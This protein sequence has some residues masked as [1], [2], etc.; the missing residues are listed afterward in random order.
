MLP[1]LACSRVAAGCRARVCRDGAV[2]LLGS[3]VYMYCGLSCLRLS[4]GAVARW[5]DSPAMAILEQAPV[6]VIKRLLQLFPIHNLRQ[7]WPKVGSKDDICAEIAEERRYDQIIQFLDESL[8]CCKQHVYIYARPDGLRAPTEVPDGERIVR[9]GAYSLFL[10]KVRYSVILRETLVRQHVD[11]LWPV[12]IELAPRHLIVRLVTLEKNLASYVNGPYVLSGRSID[13][14][15]VLESFGVLEATDLH[16]GIKALWEEGFMDSSRAKYKKPRSTAW[17]AMDEQRG[18][19]E[20]DPG[21]YKEL[22]KSTLHEALFQIPAESG[23]SVS[24]FQASPASGYLAFTRYSKTKGDTDSVV[25]EIL[26]R[27]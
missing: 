10:V 18:I 20:H 2:V 26:G 8:S 12:R 25:R 7:G 24:A 27:N 9:A 6:Q 1:F 14:D 17:E 21:L 15:R 16:R 13:E 4:P 5:Y 23:S 22:R 3:G 11:F 19:R